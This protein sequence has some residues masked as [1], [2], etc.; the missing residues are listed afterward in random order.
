VLPKNPKKLDEM[1]PLS[2]N[3]IGK[4]TSNDAND[5][6][7]VISGKLDLKDNMILNARRVELIGSKN[8]N[9]ILVIDAKERT[10]SDNLHE[11]LPT[12]FPD[13]DLETISWTNAVTG[14]LAR[15]IDIVTDAKKMLKDHFKP[16]SARCS[17]C[18]SIHVMQLTGRSQAEKESLFLYLYIACPYDKKQNITAKIRKN[19]LDKEGNLS[20]TIELQMVTNIRRKDMKEGYNYTGTHPSSNTTQ[21]DSLE[22]DVLDKMAVQRKDTSGNKD[23]REE[24]SDNEL[25]TYRESPYLFL[26]S[27]IVESIKATFHEGKMVDGTV[28]TIKFTNS[29]TI[30]GFI[31]NN[32]FHGI[33]R[34]LDA[35]LAS[36]RILKRY[37]KYNQF[38]EVREV[39]GLSQGQPHVEVNQVALYKNGF[40]DGPSWKFMPGSLLF[41]NSEQEKSEQTMFGAH[42]PNDFS[43]SYVG[44]LEN[45]KMISGHLA[46]VVGQDEVDQIRVPLFSSP[47]SDTKYRTIE[48]SYANED[49]LETNSSWISPLLVT[50][51]IEDKWVYV[52]ESKSASNIYSQVEH[53]LFAK[54]NIPTNEVIAFYGGFRYSKDIWDVMKLFDPVYFRPL[55]MEPGTYLL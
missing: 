23:T 18:N 5:C 54:I 41:T 6:N 32:S 48:H 36:D 28:V 29:S 37:S 35:P 24:A 22:N 25:L 43:T 21:K 34:F 31:Q 52:N 8:E 3:S 1:E 44:I 39:M 16:M 2:N 33:V 40:T 13:Y 4:Y 12:S 30:E 20:G 27:E 50:D 45:G 46:N 42:I 53:G 11:D 55:Y 51:P 15:F 47:I 38:Q 26:S 10:L 49:Y 17:S 9:N 14:K 7:E 19:D